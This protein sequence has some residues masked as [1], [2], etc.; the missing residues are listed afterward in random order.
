MITNSKV[1]SSEGKYTMAY[2][3]KKKQQIYKQK[4]IQNHLEIQIR[5]QILQWSV[6][7]L[8][9]ERS[10]S[11]S[12]IDFCSPYMERSLSYLERGEDYDDDEDE[13]YDYDGGGDDNFDEGW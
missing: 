6:W 7:H 12:W 8:D 1:L 4:E 9:V 5:I 2:K 3:Y 13:N 10:L 11:L